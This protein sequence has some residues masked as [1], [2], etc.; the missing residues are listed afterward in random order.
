MPIILCLTIIFCVW[1]RY[2][3]SKS[4][5]TVTEI[6][7]NYWEREHL[8]NSTR[9]KDLTNLDY[10]CIDLSKLP[11]TPCSDAEITNYQ[12]IIHSLVSQ[13]ILNLSN[14]DN[15]SLKM[16]YGI[17]NF[18]TLVTYEENYCTLITTLDAWGNYLYTLHLS[19]DA[20]LVLEYAI[21]C[22]SD[23]RTTYTTLGKLY[24]ENKKEDLL[25][26]LIASLKKQGTSKSLSIATQLEEITFHSYLCES[27]TE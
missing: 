5:K 3:R 16:E 26:S 13:K 12:T 22:G 1:F 9:K 6:Q 7:R 18:D 20:L 14:M 8:A 4:S 2:E 21:H 19:K 23:I 27:S 17:A 10:L 15:T 11:M 25:H 24:L